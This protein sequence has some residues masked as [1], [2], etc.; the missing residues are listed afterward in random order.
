MNNN[1][2]NN[3]NNNTLKVFGVCFLWSHA[4]EKNCVEKIIIVF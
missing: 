2:N 4:I 1:N 3:N